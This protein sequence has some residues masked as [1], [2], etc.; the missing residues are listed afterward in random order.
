VSVPPDC[1]P[2]KAPTPDQVFATL[3]LFTEYR[4]NVRRRDRKEKG[5][6]VYITLWRADGSYAIAINLLRVSADDRP[7]GTFVFEYYRGTAELVRLVSRLAD[8][9]GPLVLWHDSGCETSILVR[10]GKH[11]EPGPTTDGNPEGVT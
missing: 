2:G 9:C 1:G 8:V 5:Q 7:G 10:P 4:I 3:S 11:A 6:A